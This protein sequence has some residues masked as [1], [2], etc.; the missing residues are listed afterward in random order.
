MVISG[1][2]MRGDATMVSVR[3]RFGA[4]IHTISMLLISRGMRSNLS[5]NLAHEEY[6][7]G[8]CIVWH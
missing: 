5:L 1:G 3:P 6:L 7:C 2:V 8:V 4:Q